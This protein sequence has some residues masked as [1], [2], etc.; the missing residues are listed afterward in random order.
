MPSFS[1]IARGSYVAEISKAGFQATRLTDL[2]LDED[3]RKLV[4]VTMQVAGR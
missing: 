1:P 2:R 4:R 3:R